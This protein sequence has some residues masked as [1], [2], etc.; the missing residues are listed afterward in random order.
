LRPRGPVGV[1][2]WAEEP[3]TPASQ[4]WDDELGE[5]GAWDP[6]PQATRDELVNSP[7]K[8]RGLLG[9]AG[10]TP[11]RVWTEHVEYQWSVSRFMG[12]RTRFG[13]TRRKL[14]TLSPGTRQAFLGRIEGRMAR[15]ESKGLLCRGTAISAVAAALTGPRVGPV[16][17][18]SG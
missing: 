17:S 6:S 18:A 12:L 7:E 13:A 9:G 8:V 2:T 15:L 14:E 11:G 16:R 4:L 1:T 3:V 5:F 10:F